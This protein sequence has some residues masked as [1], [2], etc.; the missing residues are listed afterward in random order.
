MCADAAVALSEIRDQ[1]AVPFLMAAIKDKKYHREGFI[2]LA[3]YHAVKRMSDVDI[4]AEH[5]KILAESLASEIFHLYSR[6]ESLRWDDFVWG[7]GAEPDVKRVTRMENWASPDVGSIRSLADQ[8]PDALRDQV[9]ALV[10]D[11][12]KGLI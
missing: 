9:R 10:I 2:K 7:K 6:T 3:C 4:P 11:E 5:T 8:M 12:C 1:R